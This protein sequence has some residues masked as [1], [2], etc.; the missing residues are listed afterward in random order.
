[1]QSKSV[2][3]IGILFVL[4]LTTFCI[5]KYI[6]KFNP[7]I[8]TVKTPT[9]EILDN[10][11][12][13]EKTLLD[14]E[15]NERDNNAYLQIIKL[16]EEEENEIEDIYN[17][18]LMREKMNKRVTIEKP[19]IPKKIKQQN[20]IKKP[21]RLTIETILNNQSIFIDETQILTNIQKKK[22]KSIA[23]TIH[24][25]KFTILRI[26]TNKNN[27]K[28]HQIKKYLVT[29][30]IHLKNI[31]VIQKKDTSVIKSNNDTI[32]ILVIKKD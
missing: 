18:A 14:I 6:N 7:N 4:L 26:E 9:T 17:K 29:Q 28:L 27:R 15:T 30:G 22:L 5:T 3:L 1:M 19:L 12:L 24:Q 2:L 13:T 25:N 23:Q 11:F 21:Q 8:K 20:E 32:E 31:Q 16:V 10:H